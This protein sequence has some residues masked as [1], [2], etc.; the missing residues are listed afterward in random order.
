M[1]QPFGFLIKRLQFVYEFLQCTVGLRSLSHSNLAIVIVTYCSTYAQHWT[2]YNC[3]CDTML[4]GKRSVS[5]EMNV[6]LAEIR[7]ECDRSINCACFCNRITL[8]PSP[9]PYPGANQGP[10]AHID[11]S[12][13]RS[14]VTH[15]STKAL[16]SK[17]NY[18]FKVSEQVT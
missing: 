9:R 10:S 13:P 2:H 7:C 15:R 6:I 8:H 4:Q 18:Y 1:R 14:I 16:Q 3:L 5:L 11:D 17:G 12:H